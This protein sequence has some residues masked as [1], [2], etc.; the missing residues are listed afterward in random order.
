MTPDQIPACAAELG[1]RWAIVDALP[2][3]ALILGALGA[4]IIEMALRLIAASNGPA[5]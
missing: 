1:G 5:G 4:A 2:L 3:F